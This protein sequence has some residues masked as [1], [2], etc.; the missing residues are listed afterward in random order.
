MLMKNYDEFRLEGLTILSRKN[1]DEEWTVI[2]Q[3]NPSAFN[4]PAM[5][6]EELLEAV[7]KIRE[8]K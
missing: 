5:A 4:F 3:L 8:T 7:V 2:L 1:N 6:L